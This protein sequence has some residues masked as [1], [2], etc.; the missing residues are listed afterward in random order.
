MTKFIF[1]LRSFRLL[2]ILS[3]VS[4]VAAIITQNS[5]YALVAIALAVLSSK[6]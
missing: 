6:D 4:V 3:L 2:P 1:W 5:L